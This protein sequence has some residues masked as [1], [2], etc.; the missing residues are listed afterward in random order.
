MRRRVILGLSLLFAVPALAD[1]PTVALA[2]EPT[3]ALTASELQAVITAEIARAQAAGTLDKIGKA[4]RP[5]RAA[6][7]PVAPERSK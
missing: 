7:E 1:E 5:K 3:V 6:V 2:D 4:L